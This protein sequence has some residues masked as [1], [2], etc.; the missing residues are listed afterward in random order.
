[1]LLE[2]GGAGVSV[3][4]AGGPQS[5]SVQ[6]RP[7]MGCERSPRGASVTLENLPAEAAGPRPGACWPC[8]RS[9]GAGSGAEPYCFPLRPVL[10]LVPILSSCFLICIFFLHGHAE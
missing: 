2:R 7:W 6:G 8:R 3:G 4:A 10:V 9:R 1:M 5:R